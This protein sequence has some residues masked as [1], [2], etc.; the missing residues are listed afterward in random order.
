MT[1]KE[2]V[3]LVTE[4]LEGELSPGDG[5]RFEEHLSICP[6]CEAYIDQM[7]S[8]IRVLGSLSEEA[9]EPQARDALLAAFRDWKSGAASG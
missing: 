2:L 5:E 3:E 8:T 1:C 6:G 7:R 9:I 4:Y